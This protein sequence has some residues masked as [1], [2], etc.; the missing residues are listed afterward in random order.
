MKNYLSNSKQN[1]YLKLDPNLKIHFKI[2]D[3]VR[4]WLTPPPIGYQK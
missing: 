4:Y 3:G 2:I 1:E